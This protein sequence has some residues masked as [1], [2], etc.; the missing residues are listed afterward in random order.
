MTLTRLKHVWYWWK[1]NNGHVS[2]IQ[3]N[4]FIDAGYCLVAAPDKV[5]VGEL[6]IHSPNGGK[7]EYLAVSQ[8]PFVL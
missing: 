3:M 7:Y 2:V 5:L 8:I 6:I 4:P 1:L